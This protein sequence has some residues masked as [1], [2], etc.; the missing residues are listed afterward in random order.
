MIRA[1][2]NA[3]GPIFTMHASVAGPVVYLDS[4]AIYNLAEGDASR[5]RRFIA[6]LNSGMDLLFSVT[7]AAELAGPKG[8]SADAARVF[9]DAIGPRWFPAEL[10]PIDVIQREVT[11][12]C[13]ASAC[14]AERFLKSYAAHR[15]RSYAP[16]S[17]KVI[18][19]SP[20]FF[21]LGGL[22]EYLG[23]QRESILAGSQKFDSLLRT[24]VAMVRERCNRNQ[25]WLDARFPR[26]PFD[27]LFP[28]T[29]IF[30]NLLR[31]MIDEETLRPGDGMDFCHAV[32]AG[33]FAS[34]A[35]LDK[36]WKR[37]VG[38]L[39]KPNRLARIYGP[40]ELDQMVADMELWLEHR[41]AS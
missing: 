38:S 5:R 26:V 10:S 22:L 16:G 19:L 29:F 9:L 31:V 21:R 2:A 27:P 14:I 17:G 40:S 32:T 4:W 33:A 13:G 41:A 34:F 18:D 6:A 11:G 30:K 20:D 25:K 39:P 8:A 3:E 1:T 24:K 28:A 12:Q 35:A 23:L 15:I 36:R 37:R 7:N